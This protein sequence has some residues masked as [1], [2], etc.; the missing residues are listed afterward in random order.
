MRNAQSHEYATNICMNYPQLDINL[1]DRN[2][3]TFM[4]WIVFCRLILVTSPL[5]FILV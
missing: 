1:T 3:V 2:Q 4:H 5:F